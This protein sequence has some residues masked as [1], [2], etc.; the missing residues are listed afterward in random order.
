MG[1][2]D[3]AGLCP[4]C[5]ILGAFESSAG[6]EGSQ[7][8]TVD[9][10][11]AAVGDDDFGR[12]RIVRALG[13]GGMGA[14]YLAEQR[15][16]IRRRVA[17]KVVK[18]GMDTAQVLARFANER[19]ALAMM[20]HPNIARIFDAGSTGSGRP[21]FVME[22]IEGAP[23]TH[24]C[25]GKRMTTRERL[26]LFLAVC[27]A[28]QH[29]HKRGVIHRD[30]KPSN[31]L[32]T[33]QDGAPVPKVIDFGIAKATDKWAVENTLL[34]ESGQIVGTPEYASPEQADTMTGGIDEISDVY[35]LGV[36]LYELIIGAVP[37][38]TATLR[39]AGLAE[40][41]RIIR[42][43]EAPPMPRKLTSM[44]AAAS[45][46]AARRQTDP[47]S[48]RRLVEGD[49]NVITMK[50]LEKV[51][52][53]RYASVSDLAADIQRHLE[54]RP[55]LAS[56]PSR[57]YRTRKFL[58]RRRMAVLGT[59]A[60][61][62][63][64]LLS[65]VTVWSLARDSAARPKL[66]ARDTIVLADF[67]NKTGDPVFEDTLRQGLSVELQQSPY[68]ALISDRAVQ[69]TLT[70]MGQPKDARLTPEIAQQVC[71]RTGSAAVLDGSIARVGN[72]YILGLRA[73]EC[74]T[75]SILDQ[76]QVTVT[77]KE[78]VLNALSGMSKKFRTR[79]GESLATVEKHSMPLSEATTPSFEAFKAYSTAVRS[80]L[81][82]GNYERAIPLL[83]RAIE[84]DP[85]FA[86][87]HAHL[88]FDYGRSDSALSAEYAAKAWLLRD[89]VSDRERFYIDFTYDRQVTGNLERAYKTLELWSQTYPRRGAM[90]ANAQ[91]LLGGIS[92]QG[93]GRFE[94]TMEAAL[95]GI[96]ALPD[97]PYPY[98]NLA[99]AQFYTDRFPE[100][101]NTIQ[102]ATARKV[103]MSQL[104]M[105]Q[106]NLASLKGD[107]ERMDR[108]AASARG[109][110]AVGHWIAHAE[111]L[112]LARSGRLRAARRSSWRAAALALQ[113]GER[114]VAATF[115]AA[116]AVGEA[117]CGNFSEA[118]TA[119][120]AA[121]ELSTSRDVEYAAGLALALS[122]SSARSE[123]L[124]GDL[125]KRFPEDTF[126]KFTYAPVLRAIASLGKGRF[127]DSLERL[128]I[129]RSYELAVNGLNFPYLILGG[130]HSAY[131]R[132][133]A[134]L[135]ARRNAEAESEFQKILNHRGLVGSDLIGALA[136]LQLG[137]VFA[138]SG[139]KIKAKAAYEAFLAAWREADP[140]LPILKRAKAEYARL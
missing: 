121:L 58:R 23:I 91:D 37:F 125:V 102:R 98:T 126:V 105:L 128:E 135:A 90:L 33:E 136:H 104:L 132:G 12:Y 45:D 36:V 18:P 40:M 60:G 80:S 122:G 124:Y 70:L 79:A 72:Q 114:E 26:G 137:R 82:T 39:G 41:L 62:A 20:E 8:Q 15:E 110:R 85:N 94:R 66:T 64:L 65:G 63:F 32:V 16:P 81:L 44:G 68:L 138:S 106:Y 73:R 42:E 127:A 92:T 83:R 61:A 77:Q 95:D 6:A 75:G 103:Q 76:Q 100:A 30:L 133:Q 43:D 129:A 49:L 118:R 116:R 10:A 111:A 57:I 14:V 74:N 21:Y 29:A 53:R 31:V 59:A 69:E 56:P 140:D 38:D 84:I 17:L 112:A 89:R 22:Y 120:A 67:D 88:G 54:D 96:A 7:T 99:L 117:L 11:T 24:Y 4:K 115:I 130:L 1:P 48:L 46:V 108:I 131:A 25:D 119:A 87:A 101:E 113:E 52:E 71:E 19:Q 78:E 86:M 47:A 9:A 51:R 139:D 2:G 123:A 5:L 55:V 50:A 109:N 27:R 134:F 28:V 3:P 97:S 13:E 93:T 107:G 34:T 35:S